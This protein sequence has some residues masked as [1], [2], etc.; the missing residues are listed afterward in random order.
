MFIAAELLSAISTSH[1]LINCIF[2]L[3]LIY[4]LKHFI[5]HFI[6]TKPEEGFALGIPQEKILT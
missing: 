4:Q 5:E 6:H 1:W 2:I 3:Q